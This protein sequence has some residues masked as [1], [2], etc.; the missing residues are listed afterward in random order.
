MVSPLAHGDREPGLGGQ[1]RGDPHRSDRR[2]AVLEPDAGQQ[3]AEGCGR[4]A[5]AHLGVIDARDPLARVEQPGGERAVVGE[6]QQARGLQVEA[7]H[8]IE[9]RRQVAHHVPDRRAAAGVGERRHHA[10]RLVQQDGA[11]P[12]PPQDLAVDRNHV[13]VGI[14]ARPELRHRGAVHRDTA[15]ADERLGRAPRRNARRAQELLEPLGHSAG[16][17]WALSTAPDVAATPPEPT[18]SSGAVST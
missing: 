12:S 7:P 14:G 2:R 5:P 18:V 8:G 13:T 10:A 4:G 11:R 1:P 17:S 16:D 9:T 3:P 15:G 6:Q